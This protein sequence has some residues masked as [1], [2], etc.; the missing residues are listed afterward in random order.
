MQSNGIKMSVFLLDSI[1]KFFHMEGHTFYSLSTSCRRP[2]Q[3]REHSHPHNAQ[4]PGFHKEPQLV[5]HLSTRA[6]LQLWLYS[7]LPVSSL[8]QRLSN[9]SVHQSHLE[10]L[11]NQFL[12]PHIHTPTEYTCSTKPAFAPS[13]GKLV[14]ILSLC[15]WVL[16]RTTYCRCSCSRSGFPQATQLLRALSL[17]FLIY[18]MDKFL[19]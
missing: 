5:P 15:P 1:D 4:E 6:W 10:G 11:I 16:S 12:G 2:P 13:L 19:F 7:W 17:R 8:G 3:P 14:P 9:I 18:E